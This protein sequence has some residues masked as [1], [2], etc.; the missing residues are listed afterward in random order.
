M[1][2]GASGVLLAVETRDG[3]IRETSKE[4]FGLG[5]T[6]AGELGGPLG[7]VVLGSG[8]EAAAREAAALGA[9]RVLVADA[10]ELAAFTVD[11]YAKALDAAIDAT[12][13]RIVLLAGTTAGRDLAPFLAM[14]REAACLVD[15]VRLAWQDGAWVGTR[16]VYQGKLLTEV[17]APGDGLTFATIHAGAVAA[18]EPDPGR[19][20]ETTPLPLQFAPGEIRVTVTDLV[21][22]PA[23]PTN[24]EQAEVVVVGGR[25]LGEAANFR[26]A[27]ELAEVLG[28]AVGAT[29]AVTDLGWRPHYEQVGQTGKTI[30]PKL[31]I[32]LGVSGAV[33]H[34]VGI[35]GSETIVAINR[36]PDAPIFKMADFGVVGDVHEIAPKLAAKLRAVRGA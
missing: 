34:T 8:V 13:P 33:Q 19:I 31:Y 17:R 12:Q 10:P 6:L 36:D 23:G 21:Q 3:A 4:L 25:G 11:A 27:E 2:D 30:A 32:G 18:P 28:G 9:D 20:S 26:L 24:L 7:A 14:R 22:A 29:R 1:T 5:R 16:P 35:R 15:C